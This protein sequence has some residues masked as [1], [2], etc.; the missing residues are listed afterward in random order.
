MIVD[1][2]IGGI[3]IVP[4]G[5]WRIET[6]QPLVLVGTRPPVLEPADAAPAERRVKLIPTCTVDADPLDHF[7]ASALT[8]TFFLAVGPAAKNREYAIN[9]GDSGGA[10]YDMVEGQSFVVGVHSVMFSVTTGH[11]RLDAMSGIAAWLEGLGAWVVY[12][13]RTSQGGTR[14]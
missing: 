7:D 6:S 9:F 1:R 14:P 10:A 5:A 12:D 4:I 2:E 8:H 3:P 13:R 11:T